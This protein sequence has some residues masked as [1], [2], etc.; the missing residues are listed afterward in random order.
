MF[1]YVGR[2]R[3][4]ETDEYWAFNKQASK[5][6]G[7]CFINGKMTGGKGNVILTNVKSFPLKGR[8]ISIGTQ[9]T[10]LKE[11]SEFLLQN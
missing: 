1:K 10:E 5:D 8:I 7:T 6:S 4:T 9:H 3:G 2:R 11:D